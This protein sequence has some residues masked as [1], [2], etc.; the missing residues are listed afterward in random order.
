MILHSLS[1]NTG[2]KSEKG[3]KDSSHKDHKEDKKDKKD[4]DKNKDISKKQFLSFTL[5]Y[6]LMVLFWKS[7]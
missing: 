4:K 2:E 7:V 5:S 1:Q 3:G 6:K